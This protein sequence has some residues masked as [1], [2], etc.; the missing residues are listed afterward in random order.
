MFSLF[1]NWLVVLDRIDP[2]LAF[3]QLLKVIPECDELMTKVSGT[4]W[5]LSRNLS[6]WL[7]GGVWRMV[8][9]QDYR[10]SP[11]LEES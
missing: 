1:Q 8:R 5:A 10:A 2:T 6:E 3:G 4:E 7:H 9:V 11:S